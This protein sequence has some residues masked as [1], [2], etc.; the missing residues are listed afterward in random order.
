MSGA[1]PR[2]APALPASAVA[3][4]LACFFVSGA[5]GLVFQVAW[6]KMLAVSLG[7]TLWAITAVVAAF[8]GGLG[9]G[10]LLGAR[11]SGRVSSRFRLYGWVEGLVGLFGIASPLILPLLSPV[12][13]LLYDAEAPGLSL[14]LLL[15]FG[16]LFA[17]LMIPT[18]AMGATL[19]L[20]VAFLEGHDA[21]FGRHVGRLYAVN[22][23][24]AVTGTWAAGFLLIPGLGLR[25]TVIV[26]GLGNLAILTA[27]LLSHL[28]EPEAPAAG[29]SHGEAPDRGPRKGKKGRRKRKEDEPAEPTLPEISPG[30]ARAVLLLLA[31]SGALALIYEIA[32]TRVL[33][34]FLGS[35]TYS[36]STILGTYLL[37]IGGGSLAVAPWL[38]RWRRPVLGLALMQGAL[39]LSVAVGTLLVPRL[40]PLFASLLLDRAGDEGSLS[41]GGMFSASVLVASI[42]VIIPALLL[43]AIFPTAVEI[44]H[45][46][47]VDA[48]A[49][50]GR[51]YALNTLGTI[52]G[53]L[54]AGFLLLERL[55]LQHTLLGGA[56]GSLL[57]G[58]LLFLLSEAGRWRTAPVLALLLAVPL[59]L[60]APSPWDP[61]RTNAGLSRILREAVRHEHGGSALDQLPLGR[62]LFAEQGKLSSVTVSETDGQYVLWVSGKPD[63]S[64]RGDMETQVLLAQIPLLTAFDPR[65]VLVIGLG[66]GVTSGSVLTHPVSRVETLE[67]EPAVARASRFFDEVSGGPLDDPRH[68]LVVEDGRTWLEY[69]GR[70]YDVIISEPSNPW[71]AGIGNLFTRDFYRQARAHLREGGVF[72]QWLQ[73][74]E[75]APET[76]WA[77]VRAFLG[78]FGEAE[79]YT[80]QNG[81]DALLVA[82]AGG[83]PVSYATLAERMARPD[84]A[85][86][87]ERIGIREP[88]DLVPFYKGSLEA[89]L[90]DPEGPV[91]TDDNAY[92]EFRAP[93][94][95][96]EGVFFE[97]FPAGPDREEEAARKLFPDQEPEESLPGIARALVRAHRLH[98]VQLLEARMSE[99]GVE[100]LE[101]VRAALLGAVGIPES[102]ESV[103][104][105]LRE[106]GLASARGEHLEALAR[107]DEAREIVPDDPWLSFRRGQE[108]LLLGTSDA[109]GRERYLREAWEVFN[110]A[111]L[112][113]PEGD[114][115]AAIINMGI[116]QCALGKLKHGL[117]LFEE[118]RRL[119]PARGEAF[120]YAGRA[121]RDLGERGMARK[122]FLDGFEADPRHPGLRAE[123]ARGLA[124]PRP[125]PRLRVGSVGSLEGLLR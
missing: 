12:L 64:S 79:V 10:S 52:V 102:L 65:Q 91:N 89:F 94:D 34:V 107:F 119:D 56:A 41:L 111:R 5:T 71:I 85:A 117:A 23:L 42:L 123:V 121:L 39:G 62:V 100:G 105:L 38:G 29:A 101:Q 20:L 113:A 47:R 11:L 125:E 60:V 46:A 104:G 80:T 63:A 15:R 87:L 82:R 93:R 69:S 19:P 88:Y 99:R 61:A 33:T 1:R 45:R 40:G 7:S 43:G 44:V 25:A 35:S 72:C 26:A 77:V 36:F 81:A 6:S 67:I 55:G 96:A 48:G 13:R 118:A 17:V 49:S 110:R 112:S 21:R 51:A 54:L 28:P 16:L 115:Y 95:L 78:A 68:H 124:A 90:P 76:T 50:V 27:V 59:V 109:P 106:A 97:G 66:S 122:A 9:L 98:R 70:S 22:T 2:V 53:S 4:V 18:L 114:D 120:W 92:V 58:A 86:D 116:I 3:L 31:L 30:V 8:M 84:V 83:V 74:Y 73:Q 37:G 32:W 103:Y 108:L 24:G 57:V 14:F 75:M